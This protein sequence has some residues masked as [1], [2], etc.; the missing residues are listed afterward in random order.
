[1]GPTREGDLLIHESST[2]RLILVTLNRA[3]ATQ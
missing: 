1:M 2:D 3:D